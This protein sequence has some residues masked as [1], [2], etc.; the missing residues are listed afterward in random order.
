[1][2]RS[3]LFPVASL[4]VALTA[5]LSACGGETATPAPVDPVVQPLVAATVEA[6]KQ[7]SATV[8]VENPDQFEL[9]WSVAS[10]T[11]A[12]LAATSSLVGTSVGAAFTWTPSEEVV[13]D[14]AIT[15]TVSWGEGQTAT[16]TLNVTV[17]EPPCIYPSP[18]GFARGVA[19]PDFAWD[20][21]LGDGTPYELDL[22]EFY[23]DDEKYGAYD[24]LV[25]LI[26]TIWCPNCPNYI[27]WVDALSEQL[28]AE[29]ALVVILDVQDARGGPVGTDGAQPHISQH[30]RNGSAIRAGDADNTITP[31]GVATSRMIEYF[32]TSFVVR[33]SD[34]QVI[35]DQRDTRY[36]LPLVEIAM[37]P[38]ADWSAQPQPT[39]IPDF[40]S[41][42]SD[43]DDETFEPNNSL[44][45]AAEIGTGTFDGGVCGADPDYYFVNVDGAWT[46]RVE[47]ENRL[48]DLD[49][50]IVDADSGR[51][52]NG[53]DGQPLV[54]DSRNDFEELSFTGPG[55]VVIY[56]YA[57]ATAPYRVSVTA[58]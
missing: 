22:Y 27:A 37:D 33:R 1:M 39:I 43:D 11:I 24:T 41:N 14:H 9:A 42:C 47:F 54:S 40:P 56:G 36:Y 57:D 32:P 5:V 17:T 12:D 53:A 6:G 30:A 52:L 50:Q 28:E 4:A 21:V 55:H 44:A 45:D 8:V 18:I 31:N 23:C 35:A 46:I 19:F 13:G 48:G 3:L 51:A 15:F 26:T 7:L 29:G 10:P 49:M 16:S 20:A 58:P 2:R 38:D 34:M 25:F